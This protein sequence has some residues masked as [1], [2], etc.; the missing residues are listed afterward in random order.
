MSDKLESIDSALDL[1][2]TEVRDEVKRVLYG[3]PCQ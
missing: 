2:P 1:L 3:N